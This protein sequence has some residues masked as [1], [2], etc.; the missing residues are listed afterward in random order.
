V[1]FGDTELLAVAIFLAVAVFV[2]VLLVVRAK[3]DAT[4]RRQV[5]PLLVYDGDRARVEIE[6]LA[7]RALPAMIIE[8][9]VHGLGTARFATTHAAKGTTVAAHYEILCRP[10]GVYQIG[11]GRLIMSDPLGMAAASATGKSIDRLVV[12]P[13]IETLD[14][15]PLVRGHDPSVQSARPSF[16]PHGGEDFFTLREYRLGDDLRRVHWPSTAKRDELMIRQLEV[17]WQARALILLDPRPQPYGEEAA[18]EHAVRGAASILHHFYRGGFV[19]VVWSGEPTPPAPTRYELVMERLAAVQ[20]QPALGLRSAITRLHQPGLA[21]GALVMVTGVPDEEFLAAFQ[22]LERD[23]ARSLLMVVA[24]EAPPTM[25]R[26]HLAGAG[27][28]VLT[29]KGSWARAWLEVMRST[30]SIASPG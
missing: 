19:P 21:G 25:E 1:A 13:A 2:G 26:F 5:T 4:M 29:S 15:Y 11:P 3:P 8:D 23:Y 16:S 22:T 6:L 14:G 30:W 18:F 24:E 9:E 10:R 17:P 7:H 27:T 28:A 20:T 12:F